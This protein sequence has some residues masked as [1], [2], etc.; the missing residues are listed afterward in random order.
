M[1]AILLNTLCRARNLTCRSRPAAT[2]QSQ[3]APQ[4]QGGGGGSAAGGGGAGGAAGAK[5]AAGG[6]GSSRAPP[7]AILITG[8]QANETS[9]D[10]C[11]SGDPNKAFGA[12]TNALTTSINAIKTRNPN[13]ACHNKFTVTQVQHSHQV[14]LVSSCGTLPYLAALAMQLPYLLGVSVQACC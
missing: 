6:K 11:P 5:S 7:S 12:L 4:M 9:A 13:A 14:V 2:S 1:L 8:C 10:A 3:R